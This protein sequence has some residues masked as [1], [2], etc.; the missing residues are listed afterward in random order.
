[1]KR[2]KPS[3]LESTACTP[4]KPVFGRPRSCGWHAILTL[5]F[6]RH[7]YD[8]LEKIGH[9]VPHFFR[10]YIARLGKRRA[11]AD[12]LGAVEGAVHHAAGGASGLGPNDAQ[13]GETVFCGGNTD[14]AQVPNHFADVVD[15]PV[16]FR[17]F[18]E[19]DVGVF[20]ALDGKAARAFRLASLADRAQFASD[21]G[22]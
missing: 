9:A 1:M 4:R 21:A 18:A 16:A 11:C 7:W 17:T 15:L 8:A 5:Y 13:K 20:G 6:L 14:A 22:P 3:T 10:A 19:Q 2:F 12:R